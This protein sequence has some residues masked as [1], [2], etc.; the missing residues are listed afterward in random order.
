MRCV[1]DCADRGDEPA[2]TSR[3]QNFKDPVVQMNGKSSSSGATMGGYCLDLETCE[4]KEFHLPL[5][6]SC[7]PS[8]SAQIR[9]TLLML[10]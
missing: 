6:L 3:P 10:W 7:R 4:G 8:I 5:V 9:F 1:G 2:G